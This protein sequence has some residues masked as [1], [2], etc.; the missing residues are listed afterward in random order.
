MLCVSYQAPHPP[1]SPPPHYQQLYAGRD[2]FGRANMERAAWFNKP[3]WGCDY[4]AATFLERYFGEITQLDAAF[5]RLLQTLEHCGLSHNTLVVFTSDHGEMASCH[6]LFGKQV[7]YEEAIG[8]P[9]LVRGPGVPQN[10]REG[11]L[12]SLLD[13][14]PTLLEFCELPAHERAQGISYAPT[15]RGQKQAQSREFVI[16]EEREL[17]LR[18]PDAKLITDG[19]GQQ[20]RA[21]YD[22]KSDPMELRNLLHQPQCAPA[23][24]QL[25]QTLC[26]WVSVT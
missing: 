15:W 19:S 6:G 22:L 8:V 14:L 1:C 25:H 24:E 7:M 17:C 21:F 13:V 10:R 20:A 18:T 11:A 9:L 26:R 4:D 3:N 16:S 5:G 12:F 2:L 23:I